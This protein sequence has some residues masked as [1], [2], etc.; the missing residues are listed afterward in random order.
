MVPVSLIQIFLTAVN[1]PYLLKMVEFFLNLYIQV[2]RD[3][4][5]RMLDDQEVSSPIPTAPLPLLGFIV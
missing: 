3:H 4:L 1:C 5:Y 2:N